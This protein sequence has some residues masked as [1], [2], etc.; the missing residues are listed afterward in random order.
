MQ[1]MLM[2][3]KP[4]Y[5]LELYMTTL[6]QKSLKL[7]PLVFIVL[8][9]GCASPTLQAGDDTGGTVITL[10]TVPPQW[11]PKL[12]V[13]DAQLSNAVSVK[14]VLLDPPV[15][16][17]LHRTT[18][19]WEADLDESKIAALSKD[20]SRH[21]FS[22][23]IKAVCENSKGR[24]SYVTKPVQFVMDSPTNEAS[25]SHRFNSARL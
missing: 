10:N 21:G 22:A 14:L 19:N 24:R 2:D 11:H 8:L 3:S 15:E 25:S 13:E 12:V 5:K 20:G 7:A 4:I 16:Y 1:R 17:D 6:K 18:G 9:T 23:T